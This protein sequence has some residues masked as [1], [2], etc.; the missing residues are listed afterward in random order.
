M[1]MEDRD[2]FIW[3]DGQMVPWREAKIHVLTHTLHYGMGVLEGIRAYETETGPCIFRLDDH[4]KRM[5]DSAHILR[6]N[7]PY[8]AAVLHR[9]CMEVIRINR[10]TSAYVRPMCFLD[11]GGMGLHANGLSTRVMVAAWCWD[12]YLGQEGLEQGIRLRVSSFTRH[13]V[14]AAMCKAKANGHYINSMLALQEAQEG[15]FDEALMLDTEGFIAEGTGENLFIV[16][17]GVIYTPPT[18][19]ALE[20]ITRDTIIRLAREHGLEVAEKRITRDEIYIA[21]EAFLTGTAA[22]VT[23]VQA[24]DNRLIG[25]GKPG[26][27][28]RRLQ[29]AYFDLVRG[30]GGHEEWLCR[31]NLDNEEEEPTIVRGQAHAG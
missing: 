31:I 20:G 9:V 11:A 15:G 3:L 19:A 4:I 5:Y 23:P 26:A 10:L 13:H 29:Q 16:R 18:T 28:T 7:M 25:A 21:E 12:A 2:G 27:V 6:M 24:L 30:R 8:P 1:S 22:E 14:N 17:G